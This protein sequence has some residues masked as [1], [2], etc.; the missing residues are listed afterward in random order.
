MSHRLLLVRHA[1]SS[2]DDDSLSDVDRPLAPRG[3]RALEKMAAHVEASDASPDLVLCSTAV[4][5]RATLNGLL[6]ALPDTAVVR[7]V[8]AI[9]G[10]GTRTLLGLVHDVGEDVGCLMLVGHNPGTQELTLTLAGRGDIDRRHQ[11]WERCPTGAIATLS[12]EGPW[13]EVGHGDAS[14][15]DFFVPRRPRS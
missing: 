4:R 6:C 12:F 7:H 2:W 13:S 10:A 14:L 9:Y 15:D 3:I 5:T 1:K 11:V 8:D